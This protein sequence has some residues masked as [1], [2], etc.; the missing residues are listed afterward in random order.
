LLNT[1]NQVAIIGELLDGITFKLI[2]IIVALVIAPATAVV[3]HPSERQNEVAFCSTKLT[4]ETVMVQAKRRNRVDKRIIQR[5]LI[6]NGRRMDDGS[7]GVSSG[8]LR[9]WKVGRIERISEAL[10]GDIPDTVTERASVNFEFAAL[11]RGLSSLKIP[12]NKIS[13]IAI[14]AVVVS[15]WACRKGRK[16]SAV[17]ERGVARAFASKVFIVDVGIDS[18]TVDV[19]DLDSQP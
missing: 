18:I 5:K 2:E 9:R 8:G 6:D 7:D 10:N 15:G 12:L 3:L 11:V 19:I 16:T 4:N 1:K 13:G 14:N 17:A